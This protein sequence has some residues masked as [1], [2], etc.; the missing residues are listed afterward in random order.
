MDRKDLNKEKALLKA[1]GRRDIN[2]FEHLCKE[3]E[4]D[5]LI[6]AYSLLKDPLAA[7]RTVDQFFK[8]LWEEANFET[9]KPPIYKYLVAE[10]L[11]ACGKS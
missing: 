5:I 4:E 10:F 7:A 6:L 2:A 1:L 9:V 3:Y 8:K 11:K